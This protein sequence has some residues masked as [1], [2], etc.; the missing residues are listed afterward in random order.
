MLRRVLGGKP[1][2]V[3]SVILMSSHSVRREAASFRH[4]I[5]EGRKRL[6]ASRFKYISKDDLEEEEDGSITVESAAAD[7]L[8]L[9]S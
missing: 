8:Q 5:A 2:S 1:G 4:E 9:N 3:P 7:A 6:F